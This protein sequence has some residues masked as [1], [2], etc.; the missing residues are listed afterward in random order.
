MPVSHSEGMRGESMEKLCAKDKTPSR[1]G[2]ASPGLALKSILFSALLVRRALH[3]AVLRLLLL[4]RL[5]GGRRLVVLLRDC[6]RGADGDCA[7]DEVLHFQRGEGGGQQAEG[8]VIDL[9]ALVRLA[10]LELQAEVRHG[11]LVRGRIERDGDEERRRRRAV[12]FLRQGGCCNERCR[13]GGSDC[14]LVGSH[15]MPLL[16]EGEGMVPVNVLHALSTRTGWMWSA[17]T[18]AGEKRT[19]SSRR[20]SSRGDPRAP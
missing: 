18:V 16:R 5:Q 1:S 9:H 14:E 6:D 19:T 7:D 15:R 11:F 13:E 3:G 12:D 20:V 8:L 2:L 4:L 10:A 17:E